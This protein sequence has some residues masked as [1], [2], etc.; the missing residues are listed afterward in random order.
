MGSGVQCRVGG[1]AWGQ[2]YSVELGAWP[3]VRGTV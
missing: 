3:G 2:G 1:M